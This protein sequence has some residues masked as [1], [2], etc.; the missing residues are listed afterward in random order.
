MTKNKKG[1]TKTPN[2]ILDDNDLSWSAKG[3]FSFIKSRPKNWEFFLNEIL[4]H[5]KD[6]QT[7][8]KNAINE[9]CEKGIIKKTQIRKKDGS[10]GGLK[11][12]I[13]CHECHS[14]DDRFSDDGLTDD[15]LTDDGKS[16]T[17]NTNINNTNIITPTTKKDFFNDFINTNFE[18][19]NMT[20]TKD[21]FI[22]QMIKFKK[23]PFSKD[24]KENQAKED[25]NDLYKFFNKENFTRDQ[26]QYSVNRI[27]DTEEKMYKLPVPAI[28]SK[29]K[30]EYKIKEELKIQAEEE[31]KL[32]EKREKEAEKNAK[33]LQDM[34]RRKGEEQKTT[35]EIWEE[36]KE[37]L[38]ENFSEE[39]YENWIS[40]LEIVSLN[41]KEVIMSAPSH[42]YRDYIFNEYLEGV[43][44]KNEET[45]E[46][47]YRDGIKQIWLKKIPSIATFRI[48]TIKKN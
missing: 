41:S 37:D 47:Y 30:K 14:A 44:L 43:K 9:L 13:L 48:I 27:L 16:T 22:E 8:T 28:F 24:Y 39:V 17:N 23:Y 38:K 7:S 46:L 34:Y 19:E 35:N 12:E 20:I 11:I 33:E 25:L 29:Y 36:I 26:L 4:K 3:I 42:F 18:I 40:K 15:G 5:S 1:F 21:Y 6:K 32:K 31:Q 2:E 10:M 45:G